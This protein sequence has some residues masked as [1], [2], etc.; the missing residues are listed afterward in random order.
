MRSAMIRLLPAC[1]FRRATST[2][3]GLWVRTTITLDSIRFEIGD[4]VVL[5]APPADSLSTAP[6]LAAPGSG[7][8][9]DAVHPLLDERPRALKCKLPAAP[10]GP[11]GG[12]LDENLRQWRERARRQ[13]IVRLS[14]VVDSTGR[15]SRDSIQVRVSSQPWVNNRAIGLVA[16]CQF[17]PGRLQGHAVPVRTT[18]LFYIRD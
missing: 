18:W 2:A 3:D 4:A 11:S 9:V 1:R 8:V 15:V 14:F 17:A 10:R 5:S 12:T 7:E 13:G 16:S 6:D